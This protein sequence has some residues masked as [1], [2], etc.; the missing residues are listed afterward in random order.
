M[1]RREGL[2]ANSQLSMENNDKRCTQ[3]LKATTRGCCCKQV[4]LADGSKAVVVTLEGNPSSRHH[5][6]VQSM[7]RERSMAVAKN[8]LTNP[9]S[10]QAL[11]QLI[12]NGC[13]DPAEVAE[14]MSGIMVSNQHVPAANQARCSL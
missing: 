5:E 2:W 12:S 9:D 3:S 14:L 13:I 11:A 4:T 7:S 6:L 8:V 10:L 1:M